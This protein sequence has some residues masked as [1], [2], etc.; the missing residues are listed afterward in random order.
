MKYRNGSIV[1]DAWQVPVD[2]PLRV[3]VYIQRWACGADPYG[4]MKYVAPGDWIIQEAGGCRTIDIETFA[5]LY[6]PEASNDRLSY[7]AD[8]KNIDEAVMH[9]A[10]VH[11]EQLDDGL[12]MLIIENKHRHWHLNIGSATG[13][14]KVTARLYEGFCGPTWQRI[15]D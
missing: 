9:G 6:R 12:Y 14:A 3:A 8:K 5:C 4:D 13:R 1:V 11:L 10:D 2:L 15:D 7:D